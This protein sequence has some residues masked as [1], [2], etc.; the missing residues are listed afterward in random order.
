M[1]R[2]ALHTLERTFVVKVDKVY[3]TI[4]GKLYDFLANYFG[5][6]M[7]EVII[8]HVKSDF[9]SDRFLWETKK[10]NK[11]TDIAYT[12]FITEKDILDIYIGRIL[13]DWLE[14]KVLAVF[15]NRNMK[16]P[17]FKDSLIDN[18]KRCSHSDQEKLALRR[19][20]RSQ[21]STLLLSCF[22]GDPNLIRWILE[23]TVDDLG[24]NYKRHGE[25]HVNT[26][27][28]NGTSPLAIA[29]EYN[30]TKIVEMLLEY[31]ADINKSCDGG[32]SPLYIACQNGYNKI[33]KILLTHGVD[34]NKRKDNGFS[35]LL[36]ACS[37]NHIDVVEE[38]LKVQSPK[39]DI[40]LCDSNECTA[41][42]NKCLY[43]DISPLYIACQNGHLGIVLKL[44]DKEVNTDVNKCRNSGESPLYAACQNGHLDI[45]LKLL[46][47]EVNTDVN[48]CCDS[49]A[50]P[51]YMTCQ[52]GHLDIVLK[53]LDKE[54]NTDVNKCCDGGASPLYVACQ[55]GYDKIVKILLTH[56][57]DIN[58][59]KDDGSSPLLIAC[60]ENHIDVVEEL[61]KVQSPKVD[62][63]LCD[64]NRWTSLFIACEKGY[65]NIARILLEH[66]ADPH[67]CNKKGH[68]PFTM[69][70]LWNQVTYI[71]PFTMAQFWNQV[72]YI[73]PFIVTHV[74][75][76]TSDTSSIPHRIPSTAYRTLSYHRNKLRS[77]ASVCSFS[78]V[79]SSAQTDST[80]E[81]L[82]TL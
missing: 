76:R 22:D 45:V 6:K 61:L 32:A 23:H 47:K 79:K 4:H 50:S 34:I 68:S 31:K 80:S 12:I 69:A 74:S 57:V 24:N 28:N 3:R 44:L 17:S 14:G 25:T 21:D 52:N 55:N 38:L 15:A 19:D 9:I 75:I 70:Q 42:V 30:H 39:V 51:L 77:V 36:I 37:K 63:D 60:S 41:D 18:L 53:L 66:H 64:S 62:I 33:V 43:D 11:P 26:C 72:T 49:G 40:D 2:E 29:C 5:K 65:T 20:Y 54:V 59:R 78:P 27:R 56:G 46:D 1:L 8:K 67:R 7:P 16:S 81:L 10:D 48:K 71:S 73:S 35:P 82:R 13:R 58:K